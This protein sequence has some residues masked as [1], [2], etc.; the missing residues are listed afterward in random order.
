MRF[1][2]APAPLKVIGFLRRLNSIGLEK[3]RYRW[4]AATCREKGASREWLR[5]PLI[6]MIRVP[7]HNMGVLYKTSYRQKVS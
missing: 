1:T 7:A 6:K 3:R 5:L 4:L 2:V